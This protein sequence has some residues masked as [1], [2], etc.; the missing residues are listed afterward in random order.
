[1]A[2][3]R[4]GAGQ[5]A[6]GGVHRPGLADAGDLGR[7]GRPVV[8]AVDRRPDR[9]DLG[10]DQGLRARRRRRR[11]GPVAPARPGAGARARSPSMTSAQAAV[12]KSGRSGLPRRRSGRPPPRR[13]WNTC[14][15]GGAVSCIAPQKRCISARA[16]SG[17]PGRR[18]RRAKVWRVSAV[19]KRSG[20]RSNTGSI[21]LARGQRDQALAEAGEVPVQR[22]RLAGEGV[23]A[24]L[25]EI[26]GGEAGVEAV[27]E[28]PGAV[29]EAL[30]GDVHVVGVEHAVHEAGGEPLRA[31]RGD[32]AERRGRRAR[33]PG[34]ASA[35]GARASSGRS[36][37]RRGGGARRSSPRAARRW[38]LPMRM[39]LWL[40]RTSTEERVGEGSSPRSQRLAGLDQR[41]GL[42]G[43]DPERLEHL[44]GED[45]AHA[46]LQRQ[47][48]VAAARPGGLAG[49]LGAEVEQPAVDEI[50]RLGEE[51]AAAVAEVGV[52]G[53]E[54]V[55]VV[56]QRQR[57]REAA[58]QRLEAAE[59]ADPVRV[60]EA[61]EADARRPAI[62]AE[63]K[64]RLR[65]EG[66]ARRGRRSLRP[67]ARG[68]LRGGAPGR[69]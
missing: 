8:V 29:V 68:C 47:A 26:G 44:G 9:L 35:G 17:S 40:R 36:N 39:W 59:M 24:G 34:R 28:A 58:G 31:Q 25:V 62:V 13:S 10:D 6:E 46:A 27:E 18:P 5:Q 23:E 61:V 16:A 50:A 7:E 69:S 41:E 48:A 55:A 20:K 56:A 42:R 4:V 52:V 30:A 33:R 14:W 49:A 32:G 22:L 64:S 54:L 2:R 45:L 67:G 60:G 66:R 15:K 1:M 65:E 57:R 3:S 19:R 38:K 43:V 11:G 53:A 37:G 63:A 21:A 51:E 12:S